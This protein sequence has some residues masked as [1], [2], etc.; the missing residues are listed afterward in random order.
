MEMRSTSVERARRAL[1]IKL[2]DLLGAAPEFGAHSQP[3]HPIY[4]MIQQSCI[5]TIQQDMEALCESLGRRGVR[6]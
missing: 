2:N 1:K 5:A 6:Q 4:A 3:T